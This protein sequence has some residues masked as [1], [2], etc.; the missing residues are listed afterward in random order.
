VSPTIR[1]I[2][3]AT[4]GRCP[5]TVRGGIAEGARWT[6]FPWTSYWKGTHEPDV[7]RAILDVASEGIRGWSCWDLG[8]HFGLYSVGLA[9]LV[10]P[11]GQVAAFEPNPL[12][13]SRLNIHKRMNGLSWLKLYRAAVSDAVGSGE[14]LT[15][16]SLDS[17][18]TH[19]KYDDEIQGE[20]A[21][22]IGIRMVRLDDLVDSG[23]LRPPNFIKID[24]EGHGHKAL[25]GMAKTLAS[26]TP[27][28][29]VGL[30]S[31]VEVDGV[32]SVLA[33]LGYTWT[34]VSAPGSPGS[35]V[36][37]DYLFTVKQP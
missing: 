6:V 34:E 29:I 17:T 13:F 30:H 24:V 15:Y 11:T 21:K 32:L 4:V 27:R 2:L 16:G 20:A 25:A 36:G 3:A 26:T 33:P 14:L 9:R 19:L 22:P 5:V 10:G 23:E 1:G 31:H 18:S 35:M 8:A 7:Q 28:I 12:S 37:G